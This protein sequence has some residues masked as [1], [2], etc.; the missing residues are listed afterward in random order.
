[1]LTAIAFAFAANSAVLANP[2]A[3]QQQQPDSARARAM[4]ALA[5][6]PI[7]AGPNDLPYR[8]REDSTVP[9]NAEAY[10]LRKKTPGHTDFARLRAGKVGGQFWSIYIPGEKEDEAYKSKGAVASMPGYARVQLEQIDIAR[11]VMAKY[12]AQLEW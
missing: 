1:M 10:D 2:R 7:I 5:K 6:Q 9:M 8:I 4:R 12:P 3:L 11:R